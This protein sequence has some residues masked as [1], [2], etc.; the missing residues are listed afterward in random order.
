MVL[1]EALLRDI[2]DHP[3]DDAPWL[4]YADWLE[5]Q[6]DPRAE[7]IRIQRELTHLS[8]QDPRLGNLQ[9]RRARLLGAH[10]AEWAPYLKPLAGKATAGCYRG[11]LDYVQITDA[12]ND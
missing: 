3:Y 9:E 10:Q 5:E 6:G 7:F 4:V 11:F 2:Y 1:P 8:A 12:N